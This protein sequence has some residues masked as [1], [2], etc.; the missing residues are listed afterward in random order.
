MLI[1]FGMEPG[2]A[3]VRVCCNL[4]LESQPP[5]QRQSPSCICG[6]QE[7][8]YGSAVNVG[9]GAVPQR[10][11]WHGKQSTQGLVPE[12]EQESCRALHLTAGFVQRKP[13]VRQCLPTICWHDHHQ[14]WLSMPFNFCPSNVTLLVVASNHHS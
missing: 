7:S 9:R 11:A 10:T 4:W 8:K 1:V 5:V 12:S 14:Q 3:S 2:P 13:V 6:A